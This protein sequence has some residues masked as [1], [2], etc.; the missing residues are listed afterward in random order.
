MSDIT[1]DFWIERWDKGEIGFHN[2][3]PHE[4]LERH[5]SALRIA[6]DA[7]VFVPL[8]GK[9]HDM[10]W[11]AHRGHR[12]IGVELARKAILDFFAEAG[13]QPRRAQTERFEVF[14]D[15]PFTLY[16]GDLF[17]LTPE[18]LDGAT[19]IYDRASLVALPPVTQ[20]A[21][22]DKLARL[23][24][25]GTRALVVSLHYDPAEMSGP[26]FATP[27]RAVREAFAD[28][29]EISTLSS[30]RALDENAPLRKRGLTDLTE[31]CYVL[32]RK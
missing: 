20:P 18:H 2:D 5:W 7:T 10:H 28:Q 13:L 29:F 24:P 19:A 32:Q 4:S 11:L 8:C 15:G 22:A 9:S 27:P 1:A 14:T 21:F 30:D 17:D 3:A 25:T 16:C 26:P 12:V 6:D 31:T 23:S